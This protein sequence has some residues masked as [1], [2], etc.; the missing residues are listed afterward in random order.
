MKTTNQLPINSKPQKALDITNQLLDFYQSKQQI[1]FVQNKIS[2]LKQTRFLLKLL[3][4]TNSNT[5]DE[6]TNKH[7]N[8]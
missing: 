4:D 6:F 5:L 8:K 1:P 2:K 7:Y 3:I